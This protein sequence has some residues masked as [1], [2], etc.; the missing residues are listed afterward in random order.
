[1]KSLLTILITSVVLIGCGSDRPFQR[2]EDRIEADG[3]SGGS[4]KPTDPTDPTDPGENPN[5]T[6]PPALS[7]TFFDENVLPA[8][9]K[10]CDSCHDNPAPD[11]NEAKKLVVFKKPN[12]S[13]LYTKAAGTGHKKIWKPDSAELAVLATWINGAN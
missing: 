10:S 7:K 1:M 13:V 11:F 3:Q 2:G 8:L 5:P 6:P 4:D 12:D 9:V